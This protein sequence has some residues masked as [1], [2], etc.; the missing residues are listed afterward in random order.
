MKFVQK[1][2]TMHVVHSKI[3]QNMLFSKLTHVLDHLHTNSHCFN[4]CSSIN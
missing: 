2:G 4:R 1:C 3:F